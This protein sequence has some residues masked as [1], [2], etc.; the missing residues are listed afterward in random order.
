MRRKF[1]K[2]RPK[3][4]FHKISSTDKI[5]VCVEMICSRSHLFWSHYMVK[6]LHYR[7]LLFTVWIIAV[8]RIVFL[9]WYR[10]Y[11]LTSNFQLYYGR[12]VL[13]LS[14]FGLYPSVYLS[15]PFS[16]LKSYCLFIDAHERQRHMFWNRPIH[17]WFV[18][19]YIN[20]QVLCLPW[21]DTK[22]TPFLHLIKTALF[23]IVIQ[24]PFWDIVNSAKSCINNAPLLNLK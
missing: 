24:R 8:Y 12:V 2:K 15:L 5:F 19:A 18:K 16:E 7:Q 22:T 11:N 4:S 21:F 9:C 1:H 10:R 14:L 13:S 20:I 17:E 6:E 23:G 3:N